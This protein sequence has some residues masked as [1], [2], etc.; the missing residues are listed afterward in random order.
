VV[1]VLP[2]R[3]NELAMLEV[4]SQR[5]KSSSKSWPGDWRGL[6]PALEASHGAYFRTARERIWSLLSA[7]APFVQVYAIAI[8]CQLYRYFIEFKE[9]AHQYES[10]MGLNRL[11]GVRFEKRPFLAVPVER[12]GDLRTALKILSAL[13]FIL[14]PGVETT[15]SLAVASF[16]YPHR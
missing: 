1:D 10:W 5:E 4:K 3:G 14:S 11:Q 15:P 13:G 8:A 9:V 16:S 7:R 2:V 6:S 12:A